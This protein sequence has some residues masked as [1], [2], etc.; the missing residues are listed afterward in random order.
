MSTSHSSASV[1]AALSVGAL[2]SMLV[3]TTSCDFD[4]ATANPG[5]LIG[6]AAG[7]PDISSVQA[8]AR[9]D[10]AS[11]FG[12]E[13]AAAGQIR[14]GLQAALELDAFAGQ[15]DAD[16]KAACGGLASELGKG[17][18]FQSSEDA[19]R[20]ASQAVAAVKNRLGAGA[21]LSVAVQPPHCAASVD[22]MADCLAE[23]DAQ[24]EPGSVE[25]QCEPGKLAG[26]CEGQC[27]GKCELKAAARCQGTCH[28][29]CSASFQGSCD[30]ACNGTCDGKKVDGA[31]CSGTCKGSCSAGAEGRCGGQCEGSCELQ[32]AA[33]C[34][35]TCRG[36]CSVE[37]KAPRCE[38]EMTPP[39]AS[40]ECE[41]RCE[42]NVQANVECTPARVAV[43]VEGQAD[44]RAAADLKAA[45]EKHLPAVLKVAIGMKDQALSVATQ[46]KA[47]VD[48]VQATI[49]TVKAAPEAGARLSA[50]VAAPFKAAIDAA[51]SIRAS[52]DV[53]VQVQASASASASGSASGS[54]G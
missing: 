54:A 38:G 15:L 18:D 49:E 47:V 50:C 39:K 16:L 51:A 35:G 11:E 12:L 22:A 53:S 45:L 46:G 34:G 14:A 1:L 41:A 7:C 17:G 27:T 3:S 9:V 24:L 4:T 5:S 40:A 48:G 31:A 43:I 42:T 25:V 13:A 26:T 37:M 28:G 21:R 44:A 33:Q 36:S 10:W 19:C 23:C 29:S 30:G 32:G 8:I 52:V 2:T 6:A 20:A